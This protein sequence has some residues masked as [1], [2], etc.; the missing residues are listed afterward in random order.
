MTYPKYGTTPIRCGRRGCTWT[1]FETDLKSAPHSKWRDATISV[2]PKC[3]CE[4]YRFV[5]TKK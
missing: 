2:C 1:G 4:S 5:R 3:G